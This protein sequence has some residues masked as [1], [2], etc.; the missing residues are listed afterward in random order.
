MLPDIQHPQR[1]TDVSDESTS[2]GNEQYSSDTLEAVFVETI[3]GIPQSIPAPEDLAEGIEGSPLLFEQDFFWSILDPRPMFLPMTLKRVLWWIILV[4]CIG[5]ISYAAMETNFISAL[6][7]FANLNCIPMTVI[8][9]TY[10]PLI[11]ILYMLC[12]DTYPREALRASVGHAGAGSASSPNPDLAIII[13]CHNSASFIAQTIKAAMLHVAPNQ[14]FIMD[15]GKEDTPTDDTQN[16][17]HSISRLINYFYIEKTGNKTIALLVGAQYITRHFQQ[18]KYALIMD[19]DT[20]IPK[21]F[22]I[23][24]TLFDD[25]CVQGIVYPLRAKSPY[26]KEPFVSRYQDLEYKFSDLEMAYLDLTDGVLRPHGAASLW[27][28]DT[29]HDI[30][31]KHNGIFKGEDIMMGLIL[32]YL[33][34]TNGSG[35]L[36]LDQHCYFDTVVPQTYFGHSPNLYQQRVRAWNE[37]SFLYPWNLIIKPLLTIR[38]GSLLSFLSIKNSQLYNLYTHLLYIT[39][40]PFILLVAENPM[41]WAL[42]SGLKGLDLILTLLFNYTKLPPYLRSDLF[43]VCTYPLYKETLSMM[44]TLSFL[45][46]VFVSGA[47]QPHPRSLNFQLGHGLI[48]L[49]EE[50]ISPRPSI[51]AENQSTDLLRSRTAS[52]AATEE[53]CVSLT[54]SV[55][56]EILQSSPHIGDMLL[57]PSHRLLAGIVTE[58]LP[59]NLVPSSANSSIPR[60]RA[61]DLFFRP[62]S[63][64]SESSSEADSS[65]QQRAI[66]PI[67]M[68]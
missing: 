22:A 4:A 45:R 63:E 65:N 57:N 64:S 44:G 67:E 8:L 48:N 20:L 37:A 16:I 40:Y 59:E 42:F 9:Y 11:N 62:A 17:A 36:R 60:G 10:E 7:E 32:S 55:V 49:P 54:P 28:A 26:K 52:Y 27:R 1:T 56:R 50:S 21:N 68:G 15:N 25:T 29:L 41:Y 19:D 61:R 34:N 66:P 38:K 31:R 47:T 24:H 53:T 35:K 12:S 46:V 2:V 33:S 6:K 30:L 23:H 58:V 51:V 18:L 5:G 43:T 13:P 39:R 14:I 3:E